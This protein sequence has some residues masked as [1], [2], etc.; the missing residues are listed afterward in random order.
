LKSVTSE[1][2]ILEEG[3]SK[4]ISVIVPTYFEEKMLETLL[5]KF[6]KEIKSDYGLE[7]IVSDGGSTDSTISV[8][9][10]YADLIIE[11]TSNRKQNISEGRNKGASIATSD[12]FIF[13]NADCEPKDLIYF[14]DYISAWATNS[15]YDALACKVRAFPNEELFKDKIFYWIHNNYVKFLNMLG[16]GMG[17]GECQI[18][19]RKVFEN[20]GGYNSKLVAGEDFDLYRR[21]YK[22]GGK[23][24]FAKDLIIYESPRRYRKYG[25]FKT[26]WYWT[27]NALT[28]MFYNKS[29]SKEW[30]AIR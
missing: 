15:K 11:H 3:L 19:R 9:K 26:L 21:I 18:I 6:T 25:Y 23:I 29:V 30:E 28:V 7:L 2:K 12:I 8:A 16:I 5:C 14:L 17:R 13:L 10:L 1:E 4:N 24:Y 20:V 27:L 22:S